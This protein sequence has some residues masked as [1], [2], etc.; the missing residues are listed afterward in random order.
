MKEMPKIQFHPPEPLIGFKD[1]KI[2]A[3][4]GRGEVFVN[5][6]CPESSRVITVTARGSPQMEVVMWE[7]DRRRASEKDPRASTKEKVGFKC[8]LT[9][10]S[11]Y[12]GNSL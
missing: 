5:R 7:D 3:E 10:K 4:L 6:I 2:K 8:L 11:S 9:S 1:K 12:K